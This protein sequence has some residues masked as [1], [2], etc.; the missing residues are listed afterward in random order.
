[1][2]ANT[3]TNSEIMTMSAPVAVSQK[4]TNCEERERDVAGADLQRHDDIDQPNHHRH[5]DEEDHD[6]AVGGEDL[7]VMIRRQ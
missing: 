3:P 7:V 1:M 6:R 2:C 4:L 5:R